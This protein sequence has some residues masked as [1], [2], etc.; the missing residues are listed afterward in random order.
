MH[1]AKGLRGRIVFIPSLEQGV[2]PSFQAINAT[3]LL[4]EQPRGLTVAERAAV[5]RDV[6]DLD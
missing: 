3:G 4:N 5:I 2:F 6:A 1:D